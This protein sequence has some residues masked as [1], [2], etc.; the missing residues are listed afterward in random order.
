LGEF[1]GK[2]ILI[3]GAGRGIGK[4]LAI[5]F[6]AV[7]AHVGLLARSRAEIDLA[8]LEIEHA[9]GV[10]LCLQADVRDFGQVCAAADEMRSQYGTI[11]SL[12]AAAGLQGPIGPFHEADPK[13]WLET[14]EV[15]LLG[16]IHGCRAV[17]PEMMAR[18]SGKIVALAG[19]GATQARPNFSAYAASKAALA[20]FVETVAEEVRDCNVQVNC[21]SPGGT[22]THM[23]D[24]I[25]QAGEK[26]GSKDLQDARQVRLTGGIPPERQI[27]LALFLASER[28]NHVSGKIVHV[29]DDWKRL[30][31][32]NVNPEIYTLRR[33]QKVN[34]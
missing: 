21:M 26:A 20:R 18:R 15:N 23:I 12:V 14:L 6:A 22:Y 30:E 2:K 33:V 34:G 7:G 24:Q 28:S 27:Q 13:V 5:G 8:R 31:H 16:V 10:A 9:G 3:T 25:L 4:R 19:R 32:T 1:T 17:L 11:H 29:N